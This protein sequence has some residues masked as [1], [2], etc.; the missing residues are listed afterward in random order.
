MV[1][2]MTFP[3]HSDRWHRLDAILGGLD[4]YVAERRARGDSWHTIAVAIATDTINHPDVLP[5]T[6]PTLTRWYPSN[7]EARAS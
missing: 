7:S 2:D 5:P 1:C 6:V 3:K 4:R